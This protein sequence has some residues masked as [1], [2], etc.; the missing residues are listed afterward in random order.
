[1]KKIHNP[2]LPITTT[3]I[4]EENSNE[5]GN[6]NGNN[7]NMIPMAQN[8]PINSDSYALQHQTSPDY[9]PSS[10]AEYNRMMQKQMENQKNMEESV[11]PI[12]YQDP[13]NS[14]YVSV[15][16]NQ[17][18]EVQDCNHKQGRGELNID[19]LMPASW[20]SN[21]TNNSEATD[22][23]NWAK[24]APTKESFSR[25]IAAGGSARLS[26]NTRSARSRIVGIPLLLR[27]GVKI[28]IGTDSIP[29]SGSSLREDQI[30]NA[31]GVHPQ[32]NNC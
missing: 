29:F 26:M 32:K 12:S 25:Y 13:K 27:S 16:D 1:M 18:E 17:M 20:Q 6:G 24:Y 8:G 2:S 9:K 30:F 3:Y 31:T 4:S 22:N 11:H 21:A 19:K 10:S 28:P 7:L 23:S 14:N 15:H 5:N